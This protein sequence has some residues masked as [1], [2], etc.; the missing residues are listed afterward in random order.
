MKKFIL[1][2]GYLCSVAALFFLIDLCL[3]AMFDKYL[4]LDNDSKMKYVIDGGNKDSIIVL[5]ASRAAHHY[6]PSVIEKE[7][8]FT[9][10][11]YGMDGRNIFSQYIVANEI[12][13]KADVKPKLVLLEVAY[14]DIEDTPGWNYEKLSNLN[15]LYKRNNDVKKLLEEINPKEALYLRYCNLYRYNSSILGLLARQF[16]SIEEQDKN[17]GYVPLYSVWNNSADI[18]ENSESPEIH[19]IKERYLRLFIE[20]CLNSSSKL[21]M[22]NSPD[23]RVFKNPSIWEK[24]IKEICDEYGVTFINHSNDALFW[25]HKEWFNEPFHLNDKGAKKY[26]TIVSSEIKSYCKGE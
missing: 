17:K 21:I 25:E 10:Y 19:P 12:F 4:F 9:C 14:I 22:Y 2:V 6:V 5:G 20:L 18:V 15:V 11:N 16:L 13:S 3:G 23:F 7:T 26:S 8:G 24:K 1:F